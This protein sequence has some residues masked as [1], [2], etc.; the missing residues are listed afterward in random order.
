MLDVADIKRFNT[1]LSEN[2]SVMMTDL[3]N[4]KRLSHLNL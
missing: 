2:Q 1:K 3:K 4:K